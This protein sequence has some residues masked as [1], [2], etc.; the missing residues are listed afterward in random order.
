MKNKRNI[1]MVMT[2]LWVVVIFSL[3]LQ[4]AEVSNDVSGSFLQKVMEWFFTGGLG[5]A[6]VDFLHSII[7]KC[8]HF[9]EFFVL[10]VLSSLAISYTELLRKGLTGISFCLLVAITDET[11]QLFVG[12]RAGRILDVL[13]DGTGALVG[14][15][16]VFVLVKRSVRKYN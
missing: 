2:I 14:I 9:T 1:F 12:G 15:V 4:P 16:L 3:S 7:R 11:I 13:I 10:G 6:Q 5:Q 8:A